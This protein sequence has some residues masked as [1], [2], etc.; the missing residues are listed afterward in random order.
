MKDKTTKM[1]IPLYVDKWIFG[2][3][4]IELEPG[5]RSV[6]VDL[7]AFG[8]KDDGYIRA[9]EIT[10]YP[11]TQLA[12]LLNITVPLLDSTI[13]KC[14]HFG[15]LVEPTPGIY[16]LKNWDEYQFTDQYKNRLM[17]GQVQNAK[18][19]VPP[20]NPIGKD[21]IGYD[22]K[23]KG[24]VREDN[25]KGEA[26]PPSL[27]QVR[28]LAEAEH[29]MADPER[30]FHTRTTTGWKGILNWK[31]D[32][33]AWNCREHV[34]PP[35]PAPA[36]RVNPA[37]KHF[38]IMGATLK[39]NLWHDAHLKGGKCSF[40]GAKIKPPAVCT[41]PKYASAFEKEFGKGARV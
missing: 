28:E 10:P 13:A 23:E 24:E 38:E 19:Q 9:N 21:R 7:L 34:N 35:A 3:T 36:A 33:R 40:C 22:R 2:S 6:F 5:E 1:W 12:G 26:D 25:Y 27:S 4:R 15:K 17:A 30:Y 31:S 39:K 29:L 11:H 14:L 41:C 16:R 37:D 32:Y 8:A 20:E 18:Q